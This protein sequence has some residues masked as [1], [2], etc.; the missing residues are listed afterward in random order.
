ML[1]QCVNPPVSVATQ[2]SVFMKGQV[3][4]SPNPFSFSKSRYGISIELIKF[5]AQWFRCHRDLMC[6][7]TLCSALRALFTHRLLSHDSASGGGRQIALL[8][9]FRKRTRSTPSGDDGVKLPAKTPQAARNYRQ[10]AVCS[11]LTLG[12]NCRVRD[13]AGEKTTCGS[14]QL[15]VLM[16]MGKQKLR[17][18]ALQTRRLREL[19]RA[20]FWASYGRRPLIAQRG[21]LGGVHQYP[22]TPQPF[23]LAFRRPARTRSRIVSLSFASHKINAFG[24]ANTSR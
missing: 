24:T 4:L 6:R 15:R 16:I 23:A 22:G 12:K 13:I 8:D 2:L 1:N 3:S 21:N 20:G 18:A 17:K 5:F 19:F 7:R 9:W 10:H 11:R 14:L